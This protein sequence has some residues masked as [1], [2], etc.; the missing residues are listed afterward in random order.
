MNRHLSYPRFADD[1]ALFGET[2]IE[3]EK[4]LR[5][6]DIENKKIGLKITPAK[7]RYGP[8]VSKKKSK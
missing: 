8:I 5:N 4:M 3:L 2:A 7:L 1:I 6:L